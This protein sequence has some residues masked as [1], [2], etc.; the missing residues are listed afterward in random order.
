[1]ADS[2]I[3]KKALAQALRELMDET[4]FEK[5][6]VA[7]IC[8]KCGMNRKSFYYHFKDKYDL[9]NWIFD[10][11]FIKLMS[12]RTPDDEWDFIEHLCRYFYDNRSFYRRALMVRGQNSFS[13]HFREFIYSL[14]KDRMQA[15]SGRDDIHPMC[16]DFMTDAFE[17]A[18][19]RWLTDKSRMPADQ[20]IRIFRTLIEETSMDVC[21]H[22]DSFN[23]TPASVSGTPS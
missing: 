9:V 19:M 11:D 17:C 4:P 1:M 18:L 20:F 16:I 21:R 5:I 7:Q 6:N 10:T 22:M 13:E 12:D 23:Q 15:V 8:E 3:T 2:N 14:L